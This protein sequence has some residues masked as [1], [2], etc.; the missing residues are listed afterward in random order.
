LPCILCLRRFRL[1]LHT[2]KIR[3]RTRMRNV[4]VLSS[5]RSHEDFFDSPYYTRSETSIA[6]LLVA[7]VQLELESMHNNGFFSMGLP[8][9]LASTI[10]YLSSQHPTARPQR[11]DVQLQLLATAS[12]GS[13]HTRKTVSIE[14]LT[15]SPSPYQR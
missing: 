4:E 6:H 7:T 11:S 8:S 14:L 15:S 5:F 9:T 2:K 12:P 13:L 10:R 1:S 3:M